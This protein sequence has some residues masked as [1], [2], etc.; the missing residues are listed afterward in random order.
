VDEEE[1]KSG[2]K[3]PMMKQKYILSFINLKW[4]EFKTGAF[5][6]L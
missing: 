2:W 1:P 5:F 3:L 4:N 6:R